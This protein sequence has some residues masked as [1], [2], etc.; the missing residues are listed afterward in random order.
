M[1]TILKKYFEEMNNA[2]RIS[3]AFLICNT[4]YDNQKEELYQILSDYFFN[5][6]KISENDN[7]VLIIRPNN[8]K[9]LKEDVLYLQEKL[10]TKSQIN[11]NRVYI[12]D[13]AEKM[14]D[15]ASNSLLKFL[16]EPEE[17][18]YAFLI[19]ENINKV[20]PTIKSR[21]QIIMIEENN[22]LRLEELEEEIINKSIELIKI[23]EEKKINSEAYIYEVINKKED[24]ETIKDIIKIMKYFYY[25]TIKTKY[26]QKCEIFN[27]YIDLINEII[28]KNKEKTLINKLIIINK[29]ENMLEYNVNINLFLDK[30]LIE[31]DGESE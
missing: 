28:E 25:E 29:N 5:G 4:T 9:I 6:K 3:H 8:G 22:N 23:I 21:C 10:K 14:N 31:M 12:I 11:D 24:R 17:N 27:K 7:D 30:L 20:L 19:S 16:E 13:C 15:Y 2:K 1:S 26:N 18:I